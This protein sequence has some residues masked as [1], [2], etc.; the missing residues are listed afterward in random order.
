M[1]KSG[2]SSPNSSGN[3]HFSLPAFMYFNFNLKA[4]KLVFGRFEAENISGSVST[5]K[6][7]ITL[8]N[9]SMNTM[10]G[11][12]QLNGNI[13]DAGA[14]KFVATAHATLSK[15]DVKKCFYEFANFGQDYFTD[16]YI[17][18]RIDASLDYKGL[19]NKDLSP[20]TKSIVCDADV[21]VFDGEVNEFPPFIRLGKFLKSNHLMIFISVNTPTKS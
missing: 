12:V 21:T 18:G 20:D 7:S 3:E 15:I 4:D 17:F 16:K 9:I 2:A 6:S 5:A 19:W 14:G 1:I 10:S 11:T 13:V 8:K